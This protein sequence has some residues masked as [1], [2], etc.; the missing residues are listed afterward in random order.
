VVTTIGSENSAKARIFTT[1][2][3]AVRSIP[4]LRWTIIFA[5][6]GLAIYA[7]E[8]RADFTFTHVMSVVNTTTVVMVAKARIFTTDGFAV[9]SIPRLRWTIIRDPGSILRV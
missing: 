5:C 6:A 2:G 1:D 9:R 4:R 3:F 7:Y 8:H